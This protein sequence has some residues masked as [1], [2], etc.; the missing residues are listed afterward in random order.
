MSV[1]FIMTA[2]NSALKAVTPHSLREFVKLFFCSWSSS[3][4]NAYI[5][6]PS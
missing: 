1:Y 5:V 4:K 3:W 2:V 6:Y